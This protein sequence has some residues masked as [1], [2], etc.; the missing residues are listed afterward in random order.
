MRKLIRIL[1]FIHKKQQMIITIQLINDSYKNT[2][3]E[4]NKH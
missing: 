3:D 4:I 2:N 1:N